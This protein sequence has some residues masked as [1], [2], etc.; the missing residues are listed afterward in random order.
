MQIDN[1]NATGT[2]TLESGSGIRVRAPY[3]ELAQGGGASDAQRPTS[4]SEGTYLYN[5]THGYHQIY[6]ANRDFV[7]AAGTGIVSGGWAT[8]IPPVGGT[9]NADD[10]F[11]GMLA[12]AD[13]TAWDPNGD[14]SEALM[15]FLNGN[16]EQVV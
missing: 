13:G 7:N 4:P 14:G 12:I 2:L 6:L 8:F 1:N 11:V 10:I 16:W 15:C 5:T 9:P 3:V